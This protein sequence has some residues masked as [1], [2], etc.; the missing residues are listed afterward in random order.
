[1][2]L[3]GVNKMK[4]ILIV[5]PIAGTGFSKMVV[6]KLEEVLKEHN[7]VDYVI[8]ETEYVGHAT[9]IA[10]EAAAD[11]SVT[12]VLSVGGDGTSFE[13]ACGLIG[14]NKP[15][16]VIPAGTGNDFIKT[17]KI[18]K[19]PVE[20]LNTILNGTPRPVDVGRLN[21]RIFLNV[22]GTGF[23]V[24]VLDYAEAEKKKYKGLTPYL[25]GLIKAIGHYKPT[26]VTLEVDGMKT[27][28][29]LLICAV[30]NGRF[31]GGGIPICPDA[32]PSDHCFDVVTIG[33]RPR[34]MLPFYLPGLLKGKDLNWKI[35]K[36]IKATAVTIDCPGMRVD[37][38][39][40]ILNMDHAEFRI[41]PGSMLMYW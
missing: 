2:I 7:D 37:V 40:E 19:D 18:S 10:R 17:L 11:E 33:D 13:V 31:I 6:P 3:R 12:A 38:D 28:Q 5:N 35:T 23:D 30:A 9:E 41:L 1:M 8:R 4:Y 36:R 32:D 24:M 39:G 20:A 29:E 21:D 22:C 14:T 15:M 25:I 16:G 34:W 26:R 27:E